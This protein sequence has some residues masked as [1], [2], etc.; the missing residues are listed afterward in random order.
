[1]HSVPL[2]FFFALVLCLLYPALVLADAV[3]LRNGDRFTGRVVQLSSGTLKFDTGHGTL[4]VPWRDVQMID[5]S[6]AVIVTVRN[7]P[8]R[9][10][11]IRSPE[12]GG[13]VLEPGG[14]IVPMENVVALARPQV[15]RTGGNASA[16]L[17]TS[18]GNTDVNSLRVDGEFVAQGMGN[19]YTVSATVNQASSNGVATDDKATGSLRYDR[20]FGPRVYANANA[21]L[22]HDRFRDLRLRTA[23]GLALGYQALDTARL[24]LGTELGY[25]YVNERF[26]TAAGDRYH[27]ARDTVRLD[28]FA[29]GQRVSFFHQ[30]DG[31]FGLIG[32]HR[33]FIQARN[34][35]RI[36]LIGSIVATI[37]FDL[38]YDRAALPG[39]K[40]T[41]HTA[42]LTFGYRF[43]RM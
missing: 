17:Q 4:N 39:R 23:L 13:L 2:R 34:G 33:L 1:M 31:F 36:V 29:D 5:I 15:F 16:G 38:D 19:R 7:N 8:P 3:T 9:L 12:D 20:F 22:T 24:R 10:A 42:G 26:A 27:A 41:D 37:E 28:V 6:D 32:S 14:A 21:L 18:G 30:H 11:T 40:R 25:G 43:G 35:V